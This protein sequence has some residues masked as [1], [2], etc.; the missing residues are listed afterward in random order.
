MKIKSI[1]RLK[2]VKLVDTSNKILPFKSIPKHLEFLDFLSSAT[3]GVG[4]AFR[5][6]SKS[7]NAHAVYLPTFCLETTRDQNILT[8]FNQSGK[9]KDWLANTAAVLE[10]FMRAGFDLRK[11]EVWNRSHISLVNEN[12]CYINIGAMSIMQD[13]RGSNKNFERPSLIICD[14]LESVAPSAQINSKTKSGRDKVFNFFFS[15]LQPSV[16]TGG[17]IIVLGTILHKDGL[18]NTLLNNPEYSSFVCPAIVDG[19]SVWTNR[20]PLT[21]EEAEKRSKELGTKVVSLNSIK[22]AMINDGMGDDFFREYLCE[23]CSDDAKIFDLNDFK[24]IDGIQYKDGVEQFE[25]YRTT[26]G[27]RVLYK[28]LVVS[29]PKSVIVDGNEIPVSELNPT[30]IVDPASDGRDY[31][32][33]VVASRY[34]D[35]LIVLDMDGGIRVDPFEKQLKLLKL[36]LEWRT[37]RVGYEKSGGLNEGFYT[38][39]NLIE[40]YMHY[41]SKRGF[42][43][44]LVDIR[45]GGMSKNTRISYLQP[46][47]KSGRIYHNGSNAFNLVLEEELID[48][49]IDV[50]SKHDDFMDALAYFLQELNFISDNV[51]ELRSVPTIPISFG[52]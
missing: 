36:M 19:K 2:L 9:A 1:D 51:E 4:C 30:I 7:T 5:G 17:R 50:E 31:H 41:F 15:D 43:P 48:F 44:D 21:D 35:K 18:I 46:L 25:I 14:D 10:L 11:G 12:G 28:T 3:M 47:Y 16:G 40:E 45:T 13:I 38:L 6:F 37:L 20:L 22:N 52:V 24:Y 8:C 26:A 42:Y 33:I 27:Q 23:P 34:G 32:A 49:N 39:K 29:D